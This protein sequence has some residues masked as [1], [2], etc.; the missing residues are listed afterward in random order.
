MR[1]RISRT[2]LV[3]LIK[4]LLVAYPLLALRRIKSWY[5]PTVAGIPLSNE[6]YLLPLLVLIGVAV[7]GRTR[8]ARVSVSRIF[9]VFRLLAVPIRSVGC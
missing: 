9:D 7:S 6:L 4:A 3:L 2:F 1:I 8:Q 5:A